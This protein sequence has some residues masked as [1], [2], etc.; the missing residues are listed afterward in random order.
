MDRIQS[1]CFDCGGARMCRA[2]MERGGRDEG[3]ENESSLF[4][5]LKFEVLVV[6]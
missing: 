2:G 3:F 5:S 6:D 1:I 4:S